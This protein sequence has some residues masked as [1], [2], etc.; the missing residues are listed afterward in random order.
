MTESKYIAVVH[1]AKEGLWLRLLIAQLFRKLPG[2]TTLFLD[3]QSAIALVKDHQY[4]IDV[5][6]YFIRWVVD[7][8]QLHLI[9]CPTTNMI[10]DTFTKALPSLKVKHFVSKL[11]LCNA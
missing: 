6:F 4:H 8:G 11:G 10:T 5:C 3:N 9:Y 1:A 2:A 7:N